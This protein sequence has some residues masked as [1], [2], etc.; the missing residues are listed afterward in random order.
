MNKKQ[1][2]IAEAKAKKATKKRSKGVL[3]AA[4]DSR[5][6]LLIKA[7]LA[8][9]TIT[10]AEIKAM[11]SIQNP[12]AKGY[13]G[14]KTMKYLVESGYAIKTGRGQWRV[15]AGFTGRQLLATANTRLNRIYQ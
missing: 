7:F 1:K 10:L 12:S 9:G 3:S 4:K 15:A 11:K 13:F 2:R 14:A 5:R 8:R 6:E